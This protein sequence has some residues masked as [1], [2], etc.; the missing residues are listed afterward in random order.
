MVDF[1][2]L[3]TQKK[4]K[5]VDTSFLPTQKEKVDTSFL[6]T[7]K[8]EKP[9]KSFYK[10]WVEE[11]F[12]QPF[13]STVAGV[14]KASAHTAGLLDFYSDKLSS[15]IGIPETKDS[16]FE[17]LERDWSKYGKEWEKEG[18][19]GGV[20]KKVYQGLGEMGWKIP[21]EYM[22]ATKAL[23]PLGFGAVGAFE[24]GPQGPKQAAIEAIKGIA[25]QQTLRGA[26]ALPLAIQAPA[27]G[28]IFAG[29]TALGGGNIEDIISSGILGVGLSLTG[30]HPSMQEF[31]A[32]Y[33]QKGMQ[34]RINLYRSGRNLFADKL[35]KKGIPK[36]KANKFA[37][38]YFQYE[39]GKRGGFQKVSNRD[40]KQTVNY[41]TKSETTGLSPDFLKFIQRGQKKPPTG[42][43]I[44]PQITGSP[45]PKAPEI[46]PP[47]PP[48]TGV[49]S[50]PRGK[51]IDKPIEAI[52]INRNYENL[53]DKWIGEKD[54]QATKATVESA[55]LQNQ[56]R[57]TTGE[58]KY[59]IKSQAIDKAIQ[60]YIDLKRNPKHLDFYYDKLTLYQKNIVDKSQNLT[61]EQRQIGDEIAK[62]YNEVGTIAKEKDL[63]KNILDNYVSRIW[64]V[65]PPK[66]PTEQLRRF[67]V[68]TRHGK[69]RKFETIVEGWANG[70]KLKV[71][72][73]TNNLE[74]L[75][76]E[77]HNTINDKKFLQELTRLKDLEG[78]SILNTRQLPGYTRVEHPNFKVWKFAGQTDPTDLQGRNFMQT[79]EG[80][81]LERRGLYSPRHIARNL[82]NIMGASKLKG[83]KAIDAITK[84]NAIIK[85]W[86]LQSSLFH[87][88]AFGRS[89][90]LGSTPLKG[91][92]VGDRLIDNIKNLSPRQAYQ[93]GLKSITDLKPEVELL[94]RNGLTIGKIQDWE[95]N[96]LRQEDT[97]VG[98]MLDKYKATKVIKD[99]INA[100]REMQAG[101]LFKQFG[102]GLKTKAALIELKSELKKHPNLDPNVAA[103]RVANLM[104]D[105]F[106]G[107]HLKRMGRNPTTQ[108]IFRLFA[109][110]PDWTESNIRSAV[111]TFK[112]GQEGNIYRRFWARILTKGI[113]ATILANVILHGEKTGEEY[114]KAWESGRLKWLD[115]DVTPIYKM[116]GGDTDARK[117]FSIIGHFKD[118]LKF[119]LHPI[120]S[121]HYKGS[122]VY[123]A[124]YEA[125][126]GEDWAGR[127]YTT[128]P[129]LLKTGKTVKYDPFGKRPAPYSQLPSYV[130]G[131]IKGTQ[132]VQAQQLINWWAGEQEGFDAIGNSLGL[133]VRTT[134]PPKKKGKVFRKK[135]IKKRRR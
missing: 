106:G 82:N 35:V 67:G 7:Q 16:I 28:G 116:F 108:H 80:T 29:Q 122:I 20:M 89:F 59:K 73:A 75:K 1:S 69:A 30:R 54:W 13:K 129:E 124:I 40:L 101:F 123:S 49:G 21:V 66:Q 55:Q 83:I 130:I 36:E 103:K 60:V 9:K 56:I 120:R 135:K 44:V 5:K 31:L 113:L 46:I 71:E 119:A 78:N 48:T 25:M 118:P 131:Q 85:A 10:K 63:I 72:G 99:K 121:A 97:F 77:I 38:L 68:K 4:E 117:Y 47:K 86:V 8:V 96:I 45:A 133:G 41:L 128:A 104:N 62:Q 23:G 19:P 88:L 64:D 58:S 93:S 27:L 84:Y 26:S 115:V 100:F 95:E 102:A 132:P 12:V 22:T 11:P 125:I 114:A 17:T 87:H 52:E 92:K 105:D 98:R 79:P 107:L 109:L 127:T 32:P 111:K 112:A 2:F 57:Q 34:T 126:S 94:I 91:D 70:Y 76:E 53:K 110:A 74:I 14:Y 81:V 42:K 39:I 6:P 18:I 15:V 50:A 51:P 65:E 90:Y 43:P 33:R 61:L 134:Y 24:A 37:D 3:P